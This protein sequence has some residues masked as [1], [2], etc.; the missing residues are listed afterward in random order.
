[1]KKMYTKMTGIREDDNA[2]GEEGKEKKDK[3]PNMYR[4]LK[5]RLHKLMEKT[6]DE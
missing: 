1:M 2:E 3:V 6:A 4:Q 5:S